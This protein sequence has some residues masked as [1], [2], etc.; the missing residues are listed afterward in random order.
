[1]IDLQRGCVEVRPSQ[2]APRLGG[3]ATI[4]GQ[5]RFGHLIVMPGRIR[6]V[7]INVIIDTGSD[8]TLANP[9]LQAALRAHLQYDPA[10]LSAARAY[11]AGLPVILDGAIATPSMRLGSLV[12]AHVYAYVGDFHVF[13][14]W[15]LEDEPTLLLGMDVLRQLRAVAIDYGRSVVQFQLKESSRSGL[16]LGDHATRLPSYTLQ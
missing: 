16:T 12:I 9:A 3:W 5:L 13:E 11:T 1:L 15:G 8:S 7:A 6:N 2:G 14:L 4:R 10:R